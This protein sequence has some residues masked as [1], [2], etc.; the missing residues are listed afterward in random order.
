MMVFVDETDRKA[1]FRLEANQAA[2]GVVMAIKVSVLCP[3]KDKGAAVLAHKG[4]IEKRIFALMEQ[5][6][7]LGVAASPNLIDA[8][9][10]LVEASDAYDETEPSE[11]RC[12]VAIEQLRSAIG[13]ATS[14]QGADRSAP[15]G[16]TE[17][18]TDGEPSYRK[19]AILLD[20]CIPAQQAAAQREERRERGK[21]MRQVTEQMR[22]DAVVAAVRAA[23]P[24][25]DPDLL[26]VSDIPVFPVPAA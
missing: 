1:E 22:L 24:D 23:L 21:A 7:A 4:D 6:F 9:R 26:F 16:E 5:A 20:S 2:D 18:N 11:R 13:E 17:A 8:A 19:L 15:T 12:A 14:N 25:E 3:G 10:E